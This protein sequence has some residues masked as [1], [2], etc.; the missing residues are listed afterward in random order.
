MSFVQPAP[1]LGNQYDEDRVLRSALARLLPPDVRAAVEPELADMGALAGGE[2]Y[3]LQLADR[4]NEPR[5]VAWSPWG[6]RVDEIEVTPLWK[7]AE[8]ETA[9]R[10]VIAAAYERRHG[11]FSRLHQMALAYLFTP[12]TDMYGCPLAMTDGAA[13]LLSRSENRALAERAVPHL[14]SRDPVAFWT[15]GQWMT[16]S[17]GGSDVG[18]SESIARR[19]ADGRWR[20]HGMKSFVSAATSQMALTLARPEG[21]GPGGRGLAL[22]YLETRDERGRPQGLVFHRLKDK[23]GTRK[24]PTAEVELAG[25]VAE[26]VA[27]LVDGVKNVAP[28]LNV[29]R[30]WN[31]MFAVSTMRR[32]I[33]LARAYAP[34][35]VAFGAP[36]SEK[37]LHTDTLA[38]LQ[39]E[40]EAAFQLW[41]WV[42]EL[43]GRADAGELDDE[44]RALL[45]LGTSLAKL[46]TGKQAVAIASEAMECFGGL[47]YLE[48]TGIP[49]LLRDGQVLSIWEGT[50]NVLSLEAIRALGREGGLG[51]YRRLVA[52]LVGEANDPT[53]AAAGRI[54]LRAAEH[55]D[56]WLAGASGE[57]AAVEAGARRFATTL[58]RTLELALLVRQAQWSLDA[59]RDGRARAAA[60]RFA[61]SPI[62]LLVEV[63][64]DD[65]EAL[66]NDR[67]TP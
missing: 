53:L 18:R 3:A 22:F 11:R 41:F 19:D 10:G 33:A 67:P 23:L 27:G 34:A 60:R 45:R 46:T 64:G 32:A 7:R 9:E 40:F 35:R 12:S 50:T 49:V 48:D 57:G 44:G 59:E 17:T 2:L 51:A 61:A 24:V 58:G 42:V 29:S 37:P 21:S 25:C 30:T 28:M 63:S 31:T 20:L 62:D 43:L 8:R 26:P 54:A 39:A 52:S 13:S 14:T 16:E 1:V 66:A 6:E 55:A 38:G 56:A 36:L 15:S 65:S 5:H 47:G 4:A